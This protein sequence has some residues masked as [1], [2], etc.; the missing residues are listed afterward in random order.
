MPLFKYNLGP[1]NIAKIA[2]KLKKRWLKRALKE[3]KLLS[4]NFLFLR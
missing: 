2:C 4:N 1:N 3:K